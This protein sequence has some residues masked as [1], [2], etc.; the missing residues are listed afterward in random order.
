MNDCSR[1]CF[2]R[3][4]FIYTS[5]LIASSYSR[6]VTLHLR[7]N[8]NDTAGRARTSIASLLAL[9]VATLAKVIGAA[10]NNNGATKNTL[11]ANQLDQL[12]RDAAVGIALTIR[13]DVSEVTNV[14]IAVRWR[15]VRL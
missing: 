2:E 5:L 11:R 12:V 8:A 6:H 3:L 7:G 13:L 15:A 4:A 10:V 9:L 1:C 14:A